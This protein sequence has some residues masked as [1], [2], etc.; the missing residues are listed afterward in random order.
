[1]EIWYNKKSSE[2]TQMKQQSFPDMGYSNRCKKTKRDEFLEILNEIIPRD[3]WVALI[4]PY[5]F[6]GRHGS[7]PLG[8]KRCCGYI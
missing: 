6:D 3:G 7:P 5:Y 4:K 2:G 8:I 1:M